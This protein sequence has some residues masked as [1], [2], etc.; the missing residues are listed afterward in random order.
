VGA[1]NQTQVFLLVWPEFYQLSHLA[2]PQT[3]FMWEVFMS[4]MYSERIN[5]YNF[6][7]GEILKSLHNAIIVFHQ[8]L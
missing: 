2:G 1:G 4:N 6:S 5:E 7:G 3:F 8:T